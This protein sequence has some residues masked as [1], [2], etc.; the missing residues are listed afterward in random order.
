MVKNW[1]KKRH[2]LKILAYFIVLILFINSIQ[3]WL[4]MR[5]E[6]NEVK[7]HLSLD[8]V[9]TRL[10]YAGYSIDEVKY[11][12]D[13]YHGYLGLINQGVSFADHIDNDIWGH[14][15]K[16]RQLDGRKNGR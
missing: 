15:N 9:I 16:K 14:I 10:Q 5:W 11:I 2:T 4:L 12:N 13:E 1:N 6:Y 7:I 8:N 3:N